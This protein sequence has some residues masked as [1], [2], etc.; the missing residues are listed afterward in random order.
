MLADFTAGKEF[1][2]APKTYYRY[3]IYIIEDMS[4]VDFLL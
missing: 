3:I 4:R 2:P 1:H